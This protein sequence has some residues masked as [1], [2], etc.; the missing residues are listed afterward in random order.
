MTL[1]TIE[2][3][4]LYFVLYSFTGWV[5]ETTLCSVRAK[6]FIN[7]GFLNGPVCPIYGTG[8]VAVTLAFSSLKG[9]A[10]LLFLVSGV[11]C[12]AIEYFTSWG[13]EKLFHARWWDY[14]KRFLNINGRVCLLGFCAFGV[15]SVLVVEYAHPWLVSFVASFPAWLRHTASAVFLAALAADLRLTL[16]SVLKLPA[17]LNALR[18]QLQQARG[19]LEEAL[20]NLPP[21]RRLHAHEWKRLSFAFPN[22]RF[23]SLGAEWDRLKEDLTKKKKKIKEDLKRG[24]FNMTPHK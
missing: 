12:C 10:A 4:F 15:M 6:R 1:N 22:L 23:N 8:G 5:Y 16:P 18:E 2:N 21:V 13:M 14:S 19:Q 24:T 20:G 7:R 17:H 9:N 11:L 3:W